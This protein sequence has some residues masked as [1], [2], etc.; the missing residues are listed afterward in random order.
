MVKINLNISN[1]SFFLI[2]SLVI[3]LGVSGIVYA[4]AAGVPASPIT[5]GH[6]ANEIE[7]LLWDEIENQNCDYIND[8]A[9]CIDYDCRWDGTWCLQHGDIQNTNLGEVIVS[10]K[11]SSNQRISTDAITLNGEKKTSWPELFTIGSGSVSIVTSTRTRCPRYTSEDDLIRVG[12]TLLNYKSTWY[13]GHLTDKSLS[14]NAAGASHLY[15]ETCVE[16]ADGSI[17][18]FD[19]FLKNGVADNFFIGQLQN[20]YFLA[21]YGDGNLDFNTFNGIPFAYTN[22]GIGQPLETIKFCREFG[23]NQQTY[24]QKSLTTN[25]YM[26]VR[27][28]DSLY[29][30]NDVTNSD[31]YLWTLIDYSNS[32]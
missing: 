8:E 20:N 13:D 32:P 6:T 23:M 24:T 29:N 28:T 10:G 21:K 14:V 18:F 17:T 2:I 5:M 31:S 15:Y 19:P 12:R 30:F 7:G 1:K 26:V 27:Q 3:L 4:Y 11:I 22:P 25:K 16:N 9:Q